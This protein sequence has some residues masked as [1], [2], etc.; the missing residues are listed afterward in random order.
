LGCGSSRLTEELYSAEYT[1]IANID[2]SAVVIKQMQERHAEKRTLSWQVMDVTE[3]LEF[4]DGLFDSCVDKACL[5]SILCGESST[6]SI[7]NSLYNVIRVLKPHGV[8][9]LVSHWGPEKWLGYLEREEYNWT[10]TVQCVPRPV[11]GGSG[12]PEEQ[13]TQSYDDPSAVFFLY[14]CQKQGQLLR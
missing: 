6:N 8:F 3:K 4:P 13:D 11:L 1:S 12:E 10:V 2:F 14:I 7:A 9:L 5:D